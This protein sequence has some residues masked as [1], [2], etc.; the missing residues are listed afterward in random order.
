MSF[1]A[2]R[3]LSVLILLAFFVLPLAA[4]IALHTPTT[5]PWYQASMAASGLAPDPALVKEAV[6]QVYAAR[7]YGWR[8]A[9]AV[10]TWIVVK[11]PEAPAFTRYDVVGWGGAPVVRKDYAAPDGLWYD[12]KPQVLLDRRGPEA[13]AL[14]DEIEAAVA[15]YP[16][17]QTYHSW[18]GPNSNTFIAHVA[19]SV[20]GLRLD[21]PA[22]AIGK[23]FLPITEPI[24]RAPSGT[25]VQVSL[26]GL[27]GVLVAAEEGVEI[28][29]LGLSAGI[30]IARPALRLP[31]IGRIGL[32]KAP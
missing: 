15:S 8:G 5:N 23:D 6:V 29:L 25:G 22:N 24:A 4:S 19:R 26:L 31:G 3:S 18:P 12:V 10:H 21:V 11:K 14:I 16:F 27:A 9:A 7:A 2:P 13:E 1:R 32:P 17:A 28:D 20:P 30:D